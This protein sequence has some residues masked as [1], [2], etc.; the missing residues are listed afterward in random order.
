[1]LDI[2][3][4]VGSVLVWVAVIR[5]LFAGEP[6]VR[7]EPRLVV[8]WSGIDVAV[9][10]VAALFLEIAAASIGESPGGDPLAAMTP[11]R[12]A[13]HALARLIWLVLAIEYLIFICGAY[14]DDLGWDT[15]RLASDLR[16]G[17]LAFLAALVPVYGVQAFFVYVLDMPSVHPIV[18]LMKGQPSPVL[19]I[20]AT[21]MAVVVAPVA[22]E[23]AFRVV[24]QGWLERQQTR[25]RQARTGTSDETPGYAPIVIASVVFALMHAGHGSDPYALF[26]LSLFLG[27][28]YRQTH[29][30]FPSLV[31]HM[32]VNG[33]T[34]A[35]LWLTVYAGE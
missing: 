19:M 2:A 21:L 31:V 26:V 6:A 25:L 15:S 13:I 10:A 27:Y 12:L 4:L 9:L 34:M 11:Q 1:M 29:R 17:G 5:R 32:L 16:L 18:E 20:L 33:L 8:P 14:L 7:L 3:V 23:F 35:T 22:E 24:L 30:I 28:V